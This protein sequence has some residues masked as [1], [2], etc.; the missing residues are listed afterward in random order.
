ME[1]T[2]DPWFMREH[3]VLFS[4][5]GLASLLYFL[6]PYARRGEH[7]VPVLGA[8]V[9]VLL[10]GVGT[11]VAAAVAYATAQPTYVPFILGLT[12]GVVTLAT[13][14]GLATAIQLY[15]SAASASRTARNRASL[16]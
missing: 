13:T 2:V 4:F 10:T 8:C 11:L 12:G 1:L 14:I 9:A 15:Q 7:V 5:A 6:E 3:A 16:S